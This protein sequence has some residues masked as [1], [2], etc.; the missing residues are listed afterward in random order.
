[1]I[2]EKINNEI[3]IGFV[4]FEAQKTI[5]NFKKVYSN[6]MFEHIIKHLANDSQKPCNMEESD[7]IMWLIINNITF[8]VEYKSGKV[9]I[10]VSGD[11]I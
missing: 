5:E 9:Y 1:M 7:A 6:Q 10:L 3:D 2:F 4:D 11:I 8:Q